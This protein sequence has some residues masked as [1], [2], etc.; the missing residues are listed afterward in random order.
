MCML[1]GMLLTRTLGRLGKVGSKA[2]S[3]GKLLKL[4]WGK[5]R[6]HTDLLVVRVAVKVV[7]AD[8][9]HLNLLSAGKAVIV[10]DLEEKEDKVI[11]ASLGKKV[12]KD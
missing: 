9:K 5:I 4:V 1:V 8:N 12:K 2:V 3:C 10:K 7:G 6:E 11:Q